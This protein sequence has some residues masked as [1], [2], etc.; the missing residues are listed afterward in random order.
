MFDSLN[1]K[2]LIFKIVT[3]VRDE[4]KKVPKFRD[5][6]NGA[7]RICAWTND[8]E[9]DK[10]LG[11][12]G[13]FGNRVNLENDD[14]CGDNLVDCP[15]YEW[16]F[17]ITPGG[18]RVIKGAW[19]GVEQTVDCYAFSALKV[20]HCSRAQEEGAGLRSGLVLKDAEY[21]TPDNG[22]GPYPG[23]IAFELMDKTGKK[24]LLLYVCVSGA[25]S[26]DDEKCAAVSIPLV[27]DFCWISELELN[28]PVL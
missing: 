28:R 9:M 4:A 10:A 7:I 11:G 24:C 5:S 21:L 19:D 14:D 22:Y 13:V 26:A 18:S 23:A 25:D 17:A 6:G 3:N 12:L 16:T 15:D 27:E 1:F 8:P 20:A 2:E